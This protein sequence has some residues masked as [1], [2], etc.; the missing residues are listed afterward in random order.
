[1]FGAGV[2]SFASHAALAASGAVD[3]VVVATPDDTH[4]GVA[5]DLLEAG[6]AVYPDRRRS[7][8]AEG[9]REYPI[10]GVAAG[11]EDADLATMVEY[12]RH[13]ALGE[14]VALSPV[15]A[16]EAVA[17]AALA[18]ASLRGGSIPL[19]VPEPDPDVVATLEADR[20]AGPRHEESD[21]TT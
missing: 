1:M 6:I 7:W 19:D 14:P 4:A 8:S 12:V 21:P 5:A 2:R 9:D 17:A 3:A 20:Q 15:A 16:R 13:V 11:H 18:T 10:E